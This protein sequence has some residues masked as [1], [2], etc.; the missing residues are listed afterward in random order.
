MTAV[1]NDFNQEVDDFM[2]KYPDGIVV[3]VNGGYGKIDWKVPLS[4]IQGSGASIDFDN[5]E[6]ELLDQFKNANLLEKHTITTQKIIEKDDK[7]KEVIKTI[8]ILTITNPGYDDYMSWSKDN[9][10]HI[11][12]F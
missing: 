5:A 3:G 9:F 4:I 6:G 1:Q 2:K 8:H 10:K 12:T 7:G 11:K